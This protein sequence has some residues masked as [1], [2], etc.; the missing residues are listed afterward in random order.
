MNRERICKLSLE[1]LLRYFD[2][3]SAPLLEYLDDDVLYIGPAE[4]Q[5]LRGKD[6]IISLLTAKDTSF[7]LTVGNVK[8]RA[9]S[10]GP[11][12]C[13]V[14]MTYSGVTHQPSGNDLTLNQ[15]LTLTWYERNRIDAQG[16]RIR[17]PRILTCNVTNLYPIHT[18]GDI[19]F[20]Q[21]VRSFG[22]FSDWD[23]HLCFRGTK[24]SLYYIQSNSIMWGDSCSSSRC[25]LLHLTDG[26]TVEVTMSVRDIVETYP[27][28]FLRCHASHLVNPNYVRSL[29][30]F[31]VTMTN[32]AELPIPEKSYTA[33]KRAMND[34]Y[35]RGK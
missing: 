20:E 29:R 25:C 6:A 13:V 7:K 17:F 32:A 2:N 1:L 16:K 8:V 23:K 34:L 14:G 15:S 22:N 11:N 35:E 31:V 28:L 3:D 26:S 33:F 27:F 12:L 9:V 18:D 4:E 19:P 21:I 10:S 24:C 30:R 5:Y